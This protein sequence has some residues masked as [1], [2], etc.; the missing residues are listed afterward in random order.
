MPPGLYCCKYG[1]ASN[2]KKSL[3]GTATYQASVY[4]RTLELL[5]QLR[6]KPGKITTPRRKLLLVVENLR[7]G[8]HSGGIGMLPGFGNCA[9]STS[10]HGSLDTAKQANRLL[11][12]ADTVEYGLYFLF[13]HPKAVP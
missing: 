1:S 2:N 7:P 8:W 13:K 5:R 3:A 9:E 11:E 4:A 10:H 12:P 6:Q